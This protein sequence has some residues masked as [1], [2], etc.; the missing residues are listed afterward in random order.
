MYRVGRSFSVL[1]QNWKKWSKICFACEERGL[2]SHFVSHQNETLIL[3]AKLNFKKN[4]AKVKW[5]ELCIYSLI[6]FIIGQTVAR[7]GGGI[8]SGGK[9]AVRLHINKINRD[10]NYLCEFVT[11]IEVALYG[12]AVL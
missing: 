8:D 12:I 10:C 1:K 11:K 6:T 9:R 4:N 5:N 7:L 3:D 2:L